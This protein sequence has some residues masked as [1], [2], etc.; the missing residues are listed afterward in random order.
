MP[1]SRSRPISAS[2][3]FGAKR[4]IT[5]SAGPFSATGR[6]RKPQKRRTVM[7]FVKR[8]PVFEQLAEKSACASS[9]LQILLYRYDVE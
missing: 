6:G 7:V 1:A 2:K 3:D 9:A 4:R 8:A 5:K